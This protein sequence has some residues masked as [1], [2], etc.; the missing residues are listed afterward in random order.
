MK[1]IVRTRFGPPEVLQLQEVEKPALEDGQ[2]LVRV[3]AASLNLGDFHMMRGRPYIVRL[4][5]LRQRTPSDRVLGWD[6]AGRVEAVAKNVTD[7]KP[8]DDVFGMSIKT[9]A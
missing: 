5:G 9:L 6:L 3:H 8:G 1:A 4:M 2:V 7:F